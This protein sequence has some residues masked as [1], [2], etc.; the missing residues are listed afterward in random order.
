MIVAFIVQLLQYIL[1][2]T[3]HVS[4][5]LQYLNP[6]LPSSQN[7]KIAAL[8]INLMFILNGIVYPKFNCMA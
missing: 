5:V 6:A 2:Y 7:S 8:T 3:V 4:S 1:Q